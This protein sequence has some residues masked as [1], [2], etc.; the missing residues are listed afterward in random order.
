MTLQLTMRAV[1]S[2]EMQDVRGGCSL[3]TQSLGLQLSPFP[4]RSHGR[5]HGSFLLYLLQN[6]EDNCF[7]M[8]AISLKM[9]PFSMNLTVMRSCSH[10]WQSTVG[11][12]TNVLTSLCQT[13][14]ANKKLKMFSFSPF[15]R[16]MSE[17]PATNE[18]TMLLVK[19]RWLSAEGLVV[20]IKHFCHTA[21]STLI[22]SL[23]EHASPTKV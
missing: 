6:M 22:L 17:V 10:I 9:M 21:G 4:I 2:A 5:Q 7:V 15:S 8:K 1:G 20:T 16:F 3:T 18:S 19:R 13:Q 12:F 14:T 23:E 11:S